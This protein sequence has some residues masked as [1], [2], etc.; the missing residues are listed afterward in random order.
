MSFGLGSDVNGGTISGPICANQGYKV[1][2]LPGIKA[3]PAYCSERCQ[4]LHWQRHRRACTHSYTKDDWQPA[5]V[6][7]KRIPMFRPKDVSTHYLWGDMPAIDVLRLDS[8][9]GPDTQDMDFKICLAA[10]GD[11]RNLI[12]TVNNLPKDYRG[13]CDVLMNDI[14]PVVV[15]RNLLILFAL[16]GAG[17]Q[18][19]KLQNSRRTSSNASYLQRCIDY[20]YGYRSEG[21]MSYRVALCTRGP[22]KIYSMQTTAGMKQP[23]EMFQSTFD[24]ATAITSM[25][26]TYNEAANSDDHDRLL[27]KLVPA[28]RLAFKRY[29]DTGILVP[30]SHNI[31]TFTQ[32]NRFLFTSRGQWIPGN[33]SPLCGWDMS[34]VLDSGARHSIDFADV[35]GCLFFHVKDQLRE[36]AKRMKEFNI[37][38]HLTQY[39]AK[40]LSKGIFAGLLPAFN[41]PCFDRV[42]ASHLVDGVGVK[43]CLADWGPLLRKGNPCAAILMHSR[44]W[45]MNR[46]DASAQAHPRTVEWLMKKCYNMPGL[47]TNFHEMFS[48]GL[49]SP[50]LLHLVESLDAFYDNETAFHRYLREREVYPTMENLGLRMRHVHNIHPKRFGVPIGTAHQRL[51]DLTKDEF[52]RLFTLGGANLLVRFMEFEHAEEE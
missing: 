3:C 48:Q 9:E 44:S 13:K 52:Y 37:H 50:V 49:Q 6:V 34:A 39:D 10:S 40:I 5:W 8:N 22:G 30:F 38:L 32:P 11:I 36:F 15:N 16:L 35:F 26:R 29:R 14:D 20:V 2:T 21:D 18:S 31:S 33:T 24:L 7:E 45:H 12:Q 23:L 47:Q 1:C 17:P 46:P 28:H 42:D 4:K 27:S 19:T 25:R 43:A 51:P 41:G